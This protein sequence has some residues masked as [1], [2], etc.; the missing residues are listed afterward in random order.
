MSGNSFIDMA[1]PIA[2]TIATGGTAAPT[3]A[4]SG[5]GATGLIGAAGAQA[6]G[7]GA[8][9]GLLGSAA[10]ASAPIAGSIGSEMTQTA[11]GNFVNPDYFIGESLGKPLYTGNGDFMSKASNLMGNFDG[12]KMPQMPQQRQQQQTQQGAQPQAQQPQ[13]QQPVNTGL[14]YGGQ[15]QYQPTSQE[16]LLRQLLAKRGY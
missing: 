10:T 6:A 4:G 2:A 8:G 1:L 9:A 11:A 5:A 13:S 7:Y 16:D 3:L 15:E 14:M 12:M